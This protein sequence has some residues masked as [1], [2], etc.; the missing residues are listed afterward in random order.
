[1]TRHKKLCEAVRQL[2]EELSEQGGVRRARGPVTL[3]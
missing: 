3:P 1:M 2:C